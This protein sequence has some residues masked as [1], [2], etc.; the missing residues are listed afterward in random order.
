MINKIIFLNLTPKKHLFIY[1]IS[2]TCIFIIGLLSSKLKTYD[3]YYVTG[4][5]S[6]DK[7][8]SITV[9]FPYDKVDILKENPHIEYLNKEYEIT[10]IIYSEPY[11]NDQIPY[12]DIKLI[13]DLQS[14]DPIINFKILY[15]K[16]RIISKIKNIVKGE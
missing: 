5:V 8:C 13:T 7:N 6:C 3:S 1:S 10:S 16:Q 2:I 12:E 15:N 11:L 9:S 4:L 14:A